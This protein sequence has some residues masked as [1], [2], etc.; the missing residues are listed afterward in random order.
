MAQFVYIDSLG[1]GTTIGRVD[2]S[3]L[4]TGSVMCHLLIGNRKKSGG[5][6]GVLQAGG[7]SATQVPWN[8]Q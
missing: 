6:Y 1:N 7:K 4:H 3:G 5:Y 2:V 8:F